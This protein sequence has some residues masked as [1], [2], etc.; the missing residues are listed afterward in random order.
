M[1]FQNLKQMAKGITGLTD[2]TIRGH[3]LHQLERAKWR[4]WN[5]QG[6]RGLIGL[7]HLRHW[8][9]ARCFEHIPVLTKLGHALVD[10]IRYL[11]LNADSMPNYGKRFRSGS[12]ISTG[13]AESAVNE[14]IARRMNKCQQMRWNRH[15]VQTFLEVRI[16]VL[17]RTLEDAFRYWHA[18]FRPLADNSQVAMAA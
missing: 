16:H 9:R 5:G 6:R 2:G 4:F 10:T 8:A 13:F 14:I 7:V 18:E 15:T 12:R 17:N 3:A 1:R 11:E